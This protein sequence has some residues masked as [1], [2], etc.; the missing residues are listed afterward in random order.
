MKK[1]KYSLTAKERKELRKSK[2]KSAQ[3]SSTVLSDTAETQIGDEQVLAEKKPKLKWWAML[4]IMTLGLALVLTAILLPFTC[5]EYRYVNNPVAKIEL[6]NGMTLEFEIFEDSCPIAATNFIFLAKNKFFNNTIIFDIQQGW[7]RFGNYKTM[8]TYVSD[9]E[10]YCAK[11][12]GFSESH[13]DNKFGYRLQADSSSDAK[14]YNEE[15]ML[16]YNYKQ[17]SNEFFISSA[18]N[19][20]T[21]MNS[22]DYTPSVFGRYLNDKTLENVKIISEMPLD[23]N[24]P[25]IK[26][27]GPSPAILIKNVKLYNLDNKKWKNFMF[28]DYMNTMGTNGTSVIT[29]WYAS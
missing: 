23:E 10:E 2:D 22:I 19:C 11:L 1:K 17:S 12:K 7:V 27:K 24:S 14:R 21:N 4:I 25:S 16:T 15:G 29:S 13:K 3:K 5:N 26:W 9:D 6:S 18:R 28:E 8:T 20:Q